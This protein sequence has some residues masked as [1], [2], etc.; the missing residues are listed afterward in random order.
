MLKET[1]QRNNHFMFFVKHFNPG[2]YD[3]LFIHVTIVT[4]IK[5]INN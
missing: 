2:D 4:I 3:V 1:N 5:K